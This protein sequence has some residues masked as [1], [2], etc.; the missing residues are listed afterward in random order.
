MKIRDGSPKT[1]DEPKT[2]PD[3]VPKKK[4]SCYDPGE[5]KATENSV[6]KSGQIKKMMETQRYNINHQS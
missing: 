6:D 5:G 2:T 1:S 3:F 4:N